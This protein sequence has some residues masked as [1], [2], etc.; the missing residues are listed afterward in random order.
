MTPPFLCLCWQLPP[1]ASNKLK[2]V[3]G[4]SAKHSVKKSKIES[5]RPSKAKNHPP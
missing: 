2:L 5:I 3:F 1:I 4:P